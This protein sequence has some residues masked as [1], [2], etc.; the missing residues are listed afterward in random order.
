MLEAHKL[1]RER[2]T[3]CLLKRMPKEV[4]MD[5]FTEQYSG[6]TKAAFVCEPIAT[7]GDGTPKNHRIKRWNYTENTPVLL[8]FAGRRAPAEV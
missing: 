6:K 8:S 5:Y 7:W 1:K 2:A 3:S 4:K